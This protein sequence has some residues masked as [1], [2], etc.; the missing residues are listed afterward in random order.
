MI[1]NLR[2]KKGLQE[3]I[4]IE[5]SPTIKTFLNDKL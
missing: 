2:E 1:E 3:L 5:E 4:E